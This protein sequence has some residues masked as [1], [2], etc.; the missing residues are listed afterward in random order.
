MHFTVRRVA[1]IGA[2]GLFTAATVALTG[3]PAAAHVTVSPS[4]TTAGSYAVLTMGVPHG[5]DGSATTKVSIKIPD[6]IVT[7]TPTVNPNWTVEKVMAALNP[8]ITDGHGNEVTQRVTEVVYT[9]NTPLPDDL[10]DKF[11][12]SVKLPDTA[13]ETL[14]FPSVQ[15]CEQGEAAW[16]QLPEAGQEGHE[17]DYPAPK[18]VVTAKADA[19]DTADAAHDAEEQ[20]VAQTST[21]SEGGTG[22]VAWIALGLGALG[23]VAGGLALVR[24]RR[25]A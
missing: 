1:Q 4:V 18:F 24:T 23:L 25:T 7:V 17:L 16:V 5:C 15:T 10:R 6:Q 14:V 22:A 8:P 13:G 20:P 2:L 3:S 21:E 12:L 11:E 19:A 9:A